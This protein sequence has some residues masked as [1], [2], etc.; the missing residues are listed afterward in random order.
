[1][2][3]IYESILTD[4]LNGNKKDAFRSVI[5]EADSIEGFSDYVWELCEAG[6][7]SLD[8]F[9][10]VSRWLSVFQGLSK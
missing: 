10:S 4:Y 6:Q 5:T 3:S 2:Y 7:L 1:M 8:K 9:Y